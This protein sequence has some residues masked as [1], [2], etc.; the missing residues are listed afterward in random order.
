VFI[1]NIPRIHRWTF[2]HCALNKLKIAKTN[3]RRPE[4]EEEEATGGGGRPR[5]ARSSMQQ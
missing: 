1:Y 5:G 4:V 3:R 2:I